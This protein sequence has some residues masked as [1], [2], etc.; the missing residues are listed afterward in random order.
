MALRDTNGYRS[1]RH[2]RHFRR[3]INP[4][5]HLH[6]KA[7]AAAEAL[8]E[9]EVAVEA[10]RDLAV[11]VGVV[12]VEAD[13]DLEE[14]VQEMIVVAAVG[15]SSDSGRKNIYSLSI[16]IQQCDF[17]CCLTIFLSACALLVLLH[18]LY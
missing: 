1:V 8:E 10:D 13:R 5:L 3:I 7:E 17:L 18:A 16:L 12:L 4:H 14:S 11:E 2:C 6:F 15:T 9:A